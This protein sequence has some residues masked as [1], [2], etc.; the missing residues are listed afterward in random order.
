MVDIKKACMKD[1]K[2]NGDLKN[3]LATPKPA[4]KPIFKTRFKPGNSNQN[5][6]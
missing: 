2:F 4:T 1:G 5:Q 6:N 3:I